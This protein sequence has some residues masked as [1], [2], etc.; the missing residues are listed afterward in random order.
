MVAKAILTKRCLCIDKR[1]F[2]ERPKSYPLR[3][4]A[5]ITVGNEFP[6]RLEPGEVLPFRGWPPADRE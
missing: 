2:E 5:E 4:S 6:E 3:R 1:G